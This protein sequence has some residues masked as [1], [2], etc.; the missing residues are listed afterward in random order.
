MADIS[1]KRTHP[2]GIDTGKQKLLKL[3]TKFQASRPEMIDKIEWNPAQTGATASGKMFTAQFQVTDNGLSV[4][5]E[6]KGFVAKMAKGVVQGQLEKTV[7]EEF[8]S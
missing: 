3:V 7:A 1:L 5:V 6:L 8:P 2:F 4:D